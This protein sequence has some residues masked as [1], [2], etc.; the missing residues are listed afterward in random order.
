MIDTRGLIPIV[1][2][3]KG[4][5]GSRVL[6][7]ILTASPEIFMDR[8]TSAN[9]KDSQGCR[10]LFELQGAPVED[11][12]KEIESFMASILAPIPQ[13]DF[14][15]LKFFGWKQP[16]MIRQIDALFQA[17]PELRFLHLVRDPAAVAKGRLWRKGYKRR[18]MNNRIGPNFDY[19]RVILR[20]WVVANRPVWLKYKDHP[21]YRLVRYEDIVA[22]PRQEVA[23]IFDWLG[24]A[25]Y[26]LD[27]VVAFIKPPENALDRGS[28]VD[29]SVIAR[30]VRE[31]GYGDRL[32][33][34]DGKPSG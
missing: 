31:L 30:A 5:S 4:G 25:E 23:R 22:K 24:V 20:R 33:K 15:R 17:H 28:D 6:R 13:P 34:P 21:R 2:G 11:K 19:D 12:I 3:C 7:E 18:L 32:E 1:I 9:S 26:D 16:R 27:R 10:K 8:N 14:S 29:L